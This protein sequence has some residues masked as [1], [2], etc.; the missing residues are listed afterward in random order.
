MLLPISSQTL[1]PLAAAAATDSQLAAEQIVLLPLWEVLEGGADYMTS[2]YLPEAQLYSNAG[3]LLGQLW[4][5]PSAPGTGRTPIYRLFNGG[6]DHMDSTAASEGIY[7]SQGYL[8]YPW[9]AGNQPAGTQQMYRGLNT[10]TGD[11]SLQ[12]PYYDFGHSREYFPA[13]GYPRYGDLVEVQTLT[14]SKISLSSNMAA[15]GHVWTFTYGGHQYLVTNTGS[16]PEV[17]RGMQSSLAFP[18]ESGALPTE[19]GDSMGFADQRLS[20]GA[21]MAQPISQTAN[22]Q[23][24]LAVPLEWN[25]TPFGGGS[26]APVAYKDWK[27]GKTVTLDTINLGTGYTSLKGQVAHYL[28]R[29]THPTQLTGAQIEVPTAHLTPDL[30]RIF[31]F[32]ASKSNTV[33]GTYAVP[34]SELADGHFQYNLPTSGGIIAANSGLTRAFGI[35]ASQRPGTSVNGPAG[36]SANYAVVR[37]HAD[38][39][40]VAAVWGPGTLPAGTQTFNAYVCVGTFD[41]VRTIMRRL[42]MQG[43]R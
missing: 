24:T 10:A 11:H 3:R 29:F 15:G 35:Y 22:A 19:G 38:T 20:H 34:A 5:V 2:S 40:K 1:R 12:S 8:G 41:E 31:A 17:G 7:T 25:P 21:P 37:T 36:E 18:P 27:L 32:N 33:N 13:Y 43:Y 6:G 42:Y 4:Y 39:T 9:T 26:G 14:G 16:T 28:T 30:S 23:T